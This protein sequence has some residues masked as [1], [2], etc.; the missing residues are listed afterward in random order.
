M[1]PGGLELADIFED[2]VAPVTSI[3][4]TAGAG[5]NNPVYIGYTA[6]SFGSISGEIVSG[7]PLLQLISS[8]GGTLGSVSF[9][10][11]V[12]SPLTGKTVWVNGTEY[13]TNWSGWSLISGDT[14]ATWGPGAGSAP[15]FAEF[16]TYT[17]EIK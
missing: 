1:L 17:I 16:S 3:T 15:P 7:A 8:E 14:V 4:L 11:D 12:V 10:G 2:I 5:G 6:G 9:D 13:A